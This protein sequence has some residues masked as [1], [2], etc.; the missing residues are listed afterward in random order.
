MAGKGTER[1]KI[2]LTFGLLV[3]LL[4]VVYFRFIHKKKPRAAAPSPPSPAVSL[5]LDVPQIAFPKQREAQF[6]TSAV[7]EQKRPPIRDIFAPP[8]SPKTASQQSGVG[9]LSLKL[10]GTIVGRGKPVAIINDQ[11]V[12]SGDWIGEYRVVRI[13][14]DK[15]LLDSE[16]D[17]MVL[18][19]LE[20]VKKR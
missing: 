7:L 2:Y 12:R 20:G 5:Q 8:G 9:I 18:E 11:F 10:K 16:G 4:V 6:L 13:T 3:V 15:V 17:Q 19:V 14:K 1:A